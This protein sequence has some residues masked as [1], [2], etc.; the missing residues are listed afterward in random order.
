MQPQVNQ[1][2][3]LVELDWDDDTEAEREPEGPLE[4]EEGLPQ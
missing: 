3:Y 4:Q 1:E 2:E